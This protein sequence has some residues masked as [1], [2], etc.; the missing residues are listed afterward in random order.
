MTQGAQKDKQQGN[1]SS[2]TTKQ[3]VLPFGPVTHLQPQNKI[4][5]NI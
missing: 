1:Q 3:T 4:T 5:Q 2:K